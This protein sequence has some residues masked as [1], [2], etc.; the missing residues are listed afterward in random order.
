VLLMAEPRTRLVGRGELRKLFAVSYTRAVQI[1]AQPDF[2]EPLDE[3][4]V[5]K[6]WLLDEVAAWAAGKGRTLHL[7]ALT[8]VVQDGDEGDP[9]GKRVS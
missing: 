7:D 3:L 6:I 4:S 5:G 9:H 2:P 8:P 1:A